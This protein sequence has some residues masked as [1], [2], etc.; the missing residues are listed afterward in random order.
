M[1]DMDSQASVLGKGQL[2]TI[3]PLLNLQEISKVDLLELDNRAF[4][5]INL[6]WFSQ[7]CMSSERF[8]SGQGKLLE[9]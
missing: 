6:K 1:A 7:A 2:F 5:W 3:L 9:S 8:N 4:Y